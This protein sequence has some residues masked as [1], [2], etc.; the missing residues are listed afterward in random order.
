MQLVLGV[1]VNT[2]F[3]V[4]IEIPKPE[5]QSFNAPSITGKR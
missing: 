5:D 4:Q 3:M 2:G 1:N